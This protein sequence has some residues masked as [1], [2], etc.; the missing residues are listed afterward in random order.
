[1]TP[2]SLAPASAETK[3]GR[4][5]R[6]RHRGPA[7]AREFLHVDFAFPLPQGVAVMPRLHAQQGIHADAESLLDPQCHFRRQGR[8]FVRTRWR[9]R[10]PGKPP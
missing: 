6:L 2:A 9:S 1:M 7:G 3:G 5:G 4:R 10:C 8:F